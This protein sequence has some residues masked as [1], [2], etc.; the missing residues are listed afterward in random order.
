MSRTSTAWMIALSHPCNW[1]RYLDGPQDV[2]VRNIFNDQSVRAVFTGPAVHPANFRAVVAAFC[3]PGW[4]R[5]YQTM[6]QRIAV[7]WL[8]RPL[9]DILRSQRSRRAKVAAVR[10]LQAAV[11]GQWKQ[12]HKEQAVVTRAQS[13]LEG[14]LRSRTF[15]NALASHAATPRFL[16]PLLPLHQGVQRELSGASGS[17]GSGSL[18]TP[19]TS[20]PLR[21][22][23]PQAEHEPA[24]STPT[25]RRP[26]LTEFTPPRLSRTRNSCT[27]SD[28]VAIGTTSGKDDSSESSSSE[29][30]SSS[31]SSTSSSTSERGCPG[32]AQQQQH[33]CRE[34]VEGPTTPQQRGNHTLEVAMLKQCSDQA[35]SAR[36][37]HQ[38][39]TTCTRAAVSPQHCSSHSAVAITPQ[40]KR[41]SDLQGLCLTPERAKP[42]KRRRSVSLEQQ[43]QRLQQQQ[44]QQPGKAA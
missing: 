28:R 7:G 25:R 11:A 12:R 39:N 1:A 14:Q 20:S 30:S 23:F 44:Q 4:Q 15:Q 24:P 21:T 42:A 8:R 29:S 17:N 2:L 32:S 3:A 38:S 35:G 18:R 6:K 40:R 37:P 22:S 31:D 36:M 13:T 26:S 16:S 27:S 34:V 19:S 33:G 9:P 10:S 5:R 41:H 43:Q